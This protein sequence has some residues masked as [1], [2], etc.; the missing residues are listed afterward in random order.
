MCGGVVC[1]EGAVLAYAGMC[2]CTVYLRDIQGSRVA[3]VVG[4]RVYCGGNSLYLCVEG[5]FVSRR[6]CTRM[7]VCRI[8]RCVDVISE[9]SVWRLS[10][11]LV[12]IAVAT[13]CSCVWRDRLC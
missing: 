10:C 7:S 13:V 12:Y 3:H 1:V 2:D 5:S 8:V 9:G 6:L 11:V 4:A